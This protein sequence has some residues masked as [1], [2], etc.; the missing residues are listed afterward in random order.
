MYQWY[1]NIQSAIGGIKFLQKIKTAILLDDCFQCWRTPIFP[2]RHQP[3]IVGTN[4]LNFR[5]R[6]GNGW[7]PAVINTNSFLFA[8]SL[9]GFTIIPHP[10]RNCNPFFQFFSNFFYGAPGGAICWPENPESHR[11]CRQAPRP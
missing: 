9:D 4:G 2:G 1:W 7:T 8:V 10:F 5:V 3:S 6:D 11:F